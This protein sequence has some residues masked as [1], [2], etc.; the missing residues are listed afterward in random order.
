MSFETADIA[1]VGMA[2]LY[3][4]ADDVDVFWQN[5]LTKV[6]AVTD[7]AEGWVGDGSILDPESDDPL[8]IYTRRGGFL[9]DLSRFDA[10]QFGTMPLSVSGGQPDQFLALKV[11]HDAMVDA[12][13]APGTYDSSATGVILGHA[14]HAHRGNSNGMQQVWFNPQ[15]QALLQALF[16]DL[17]AAQVN[18]A[19]RLMQAKL[20]RIL[21][22]AVP[23]LVPNILTGRIAN[24]LDLMGP[25]YIIDAACS[26]S[27]IAVDLA[28]NELRS[29]HANM[30]LAGGVN[31]TTSP[32]V[33][34]VFCSVS[35]LSRE[36]RIRPFD[37]QASGT[38][39]GE[40]CGMVVLK[41][42]D[43]ALAAGDRVYAVIKGVGQSS[44][45]KSSGL[46][47][48]RLEGEVLAMRRA[49]ANCGI[50]PATIGLLEAHG[51]G[52]PLGDKTEVES[53]R[54]IFGERQG[55]LP[56]VPVG[57]VKSMI[58]HCIPASGSAAII[59]MALSL[60]TGIQPPTL[61]DE[62]S[63]EIGLDSTPFHVATEARPW[64][65]SADHPRRAAINAFGFGG[66]NAH[67]VLEEAPGAA[68]RDPTAAFLPAILPEA[69]AAPEHVFAFAGTD[70]AGLM[71]AV[72]GFL[73]T[74]HAG[75]L[76]ERAAHAWAAAAASPGPERLAIVAASEAELD[77]K[78]AGL[79]AKLANP[80]QGAMQ[81]RNGIYFEP[82]PIGGKVAFLFPGEMAQYP[83]M[84]RDAAIAFPMVRAWFD[85]VAALTEGRRDVALQQVIFPPDTLVDAAGQ[86]E[87][88]ALIHRVDYGSE[89][90]F[91]ADQ[92]VFA[93]LTKLGVKA[94]AMLGHSTGENAALVASGL[95]D[96]DRAGVLAM[97]ARM[98]EIF[99]EVQASGAV[100]TGV[101][102]NV[103]A[104]E[105]AKLETLVAKHGSLHFTMDNCPNQAILFGQAEEIAAL[106][107]D[108]VAEGA[109]CTQLPISWGYHTE[110]VRPLAERFDGLFDGVGLKPSDVT[111][112]SCG[113]AAPFPETVAE[114]RSTA[115]SQY[116]SKVRFTEGIERLH[117]D[118]CRVFVE[119]GPNAVLS[120]FVRD[121][122]GDRPH[123]AV[124][125]DNRRR[126]MVAQLRHLVAQLFV[127]GVPLEPM[128]LL[129]PVEGADQTRRREIRDKQRKAPRLPSEL[130]VVTLAETDIAQLR[131]ML[132]PAR[133]ALALGNAAPANGALAAVA[134]AP[135]PA[136][137]AQA[138]AAVPV[139][140]AAPAPQ[141]QPAP[142]AA[143]PA[144]TAAAPAGGLAVHDHIGLMT[145]F[146][147]STGRVASQALG[148]TGNG[149]APAPAP[150]RRIEVIDLARLFRLP[151]ELRAYAM[152]GSPSF[153]SLLPYLAPSEQDEAREVLIRRGH[154]DAWQEWSLSRLA[155]K[156]AAAEVLRNG[157]ANLPPQSALEIRK[158]DSGAP[159]LAVDG[160]AA[161]PAISL[162]H[163]EAVGAGAAAAPGWRIG[164]DYE[165]P[166]RI[167]DPQGFYESVTSEA[168][169]AALNLAPSREAAVL[170]WSVK[171]AAAK[172]LGLGMQG[173]PQEFALLGY[174]PAQ[175]SALVQHQSHLVSAQ[176][177]PVRDA[178][179][180][181][182]YAAAS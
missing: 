121:I 148:G 91:A 68:F 145:G 35:A 132:L 156:R 40:G 158:H 4:G 175:G 109:I 69:I 64:V 77:K 142:V 31:T 100:P 160:A 26:S 90:V 13:Y 80:A 52:I 21:P 71:A 15:M 127:A 56:T 120:S 70:R 116:V 51:T 130:P 10:R 53:L 147:H 11:A 6:D 46:M 44:D 34:S 42:L 139:Q 166:A 169:R 23:G 59:K 129:A 133:A 117:A 29:G 33:Y 119:C 124:S 81:T 97:I 47:A 12:G 172:A 178:I 78:V 179:C 45:G 176:V 83:G 110:H 86:A 16:P 27:I 19:I 113:T 168:E 171:E 37:R 108:A 30:M 118:G 79:R 57:S 180:A 28:I 104:L 24:R 99:D 2:G 103:A 134:P 114:F 17:P 87:L 159:Y 89:M 143:A 111:L 115:I 174:D 5:I 140:A 151:F 32:L 65:H 112:Y 7:S 94:D 153:E 138:L 48:P 9:G 61:C 95:L 101:L 20:P 39:L 102:L 155:V 165:R 177:R 38:V 135:M 43:D 41:R 146:L 170:V 84:M 144:T 141:P 74:A 162:S 63:E 105:R 85:D 154:A 150:T 66:I 98:N 3:P 136:A 96:I 73:A 62:V 149:T 75:S 8:K 163:V 25:N 88:E 92:A 50:D 107:A 125:A 58:G 157:A 123:L 54:A 164:I 182:A 122:L 167:R 22:E 72:D 93:L 106:Q 137:P 128:A 161:A 131:E 60:Y 49:Y 14:I 126:G 55:K 173:R 82:A 152:H 67:M 1:I 181:I 76:A 18:D 36:G